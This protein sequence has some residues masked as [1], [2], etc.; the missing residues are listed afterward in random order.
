MKL[1][2]SFG[3]R[4]FVV[5][6][7]IFWT[8]SLFAIDESR[9][10]EF[11][12]DNGLKVITYEMHAAPI[13]FSCLVY[14]V[15]SK[16]E[17]FG[18]TGIS[19]IVEHMMFQGTKRFPKGVIADLIAS[20]GGVFNAY[21]STDVTVYYEL[22]P[23]NRID[24]ALDIESERMYKCVFDPQE[25]EREKKVIIEER[26]MRVDNNPKGLRMEELNTLLYK[27]HP[28]RNPVIGW[29]EDIERIT[30]DQAYAYYKKYY[31]PNNATLV[32]VG[33]FDTNEM[34]K[35]VKKYY[36]R[37][38]KGPKLEEMNFYRL[39]FHG[40]RVLEFTHQDITDKSLGLYFKAPPRFSKDGPA[41]YVAGRILCRKAATSRLYKRLVT[42]ERLCQVVAGGLRFS[43]DPSVFVISAVLFPDKDFDTVEKIIWEEI[44]SMATYPVSNY[45]LQKIKN[46]IVFDE[47]TSDQYPSEVGNRLAVYDN[48]FGW[49][50][51]NRWD[52][53]IVS[54]NKEDIMRVVRKYFDRKNHVVC[55]TLPEDSSRSSGKGEEKKLKEPE[56]EMASSGEVT[57]GITGIK[58]RRKDTKSLLEKV[59]RIFKKDVMELYTPTL[60][61]IIAPN[62]IAPLV[63]SLVLRNGVKVYYIE[64]HDFPTVYLL[65]FISTG[66]LVENEKNPGIRQFVEAMIYRGTKSRTYDEII[67]EKSFVPYQL[68]VSQSWENISIQGYSL[69]KDAGK[70]FRLAYEY[71][72]EANFPESE[73]DKIRRKLI[74]KAKNF[75]KTDAMKAFYSMYESVFEGHQYGLPY[76]GLPEVYE[77]LTRD[78]LI[79]FYKKYYSPDR[80]KLVVVGDFDRK[81]L[82]EEL[83][84]TI[85]GWINPSGDKNVEFQRIKPIK[86][87]HIF[88][89]SNPDYR[90]CRIDIA[91]NTVEGGI[92]VH[93][94]DLEALKLLEYILC[95]NSLTSRMGRKLRDEQGL[96]YNISSNLWVRIHGGYWNIRTFVDE[97]NAV[98]MIRG[99][100]EEIRKVQTEGV[101]E[102]ELLDA[103]ARKLSLLPF[104]IRTLDDVG[105]NVYEMLKYGRPLDY[106]DRKAERIR[107]VTL[108][109]IKRVA[110]KYLDT[111]NYII[112]VSGNLPEDALDEFK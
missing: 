8:S 39:D 12:L 68:K 108:D 42:E 103:K 36:G 3:R 64:Q 83:N 106:F 9:V 51:I 71:L 10:K 63:D 7:L 44:D 29:M 6:I 89:F 105:V 31:T 60:D 34:L 2:K 66:R 47:L 55:Y 85:G 26:K 28:Y 78:D 4:L 98:R 14:N 69:K 100:F 87:K 41:L 75:K 5:L 22:L 23:K 109:D 40:K 110:N 52:S 57:E 48:Y 33:D 101:T 91:F 50:N 88:V 15:G 81:W 59:L 99:I 49:R 79:R 107:A 1:L 72:A 62:P 46:H 61:D 45:E 53:L 73:M 65:G 54:V 80:L 67:E 16:Y 111:E 25:F 37:V 27:C 102:S 32:L 74:V 92:T 20:N 86:G 93:D 38:P 96:C 104:W 21:T 35:K 76:A 84:K 70:M 18:Q 17:S 77:K 56:E 30:R 58:V 82:E 19:H 112:A 11:Y 94:P 13:I 43:K 97:A 90:Q 95:G 24:L